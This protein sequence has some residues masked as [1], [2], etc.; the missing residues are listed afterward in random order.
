MSASTGRAQAGQDNTGRKG[1]ERPGPELQGSAAVR[2]LRV[3]R[4]VMAVVQAV[5][6]GLNA[7]KAGEVGRVMIVAIT[8][9]RAN[10]SLKRSL[11]EEEI[12]EDGQPHKPSQQELKVCTGHCPCALAASHARVTCHHPGSDC[13]TQAVGPLP[14]TH[15]SPSAG[16][17]RTGVES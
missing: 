6:V 8:D 3:L 4:A 17:G 1:Q 12:S 7:E 11:G 14:G 5:R 15:L 10:V 9:G 16:S 13:L 2:A